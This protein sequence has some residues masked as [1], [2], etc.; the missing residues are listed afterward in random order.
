VSKVSSNH[1]KD[2][3]NTAIS[4]SRPNKV[5]RPSLPEGIVGLIVF[6]VLEEANAAIAQAHGQKPLKILTFRHQ[7]CD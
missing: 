2:S 3:G 1:P 4:S 6:T 5:L 7:T